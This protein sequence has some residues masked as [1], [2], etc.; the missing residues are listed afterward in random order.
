M[1]PMQLTAEELLILEESN[2]TDIELGELVS[3]SGITSNVPAALQT[4]FSS[5]LIGK[6][7]LLSSQVGLIGITLIIIILHEYLPGPVYRK[8]DF[9]SFSHKECTHTDV[10]SSCCMRTFCTAG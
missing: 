10:S 4:M 3:E 8:L 6:T 1:S 7:E 5:S 2:T 9:C